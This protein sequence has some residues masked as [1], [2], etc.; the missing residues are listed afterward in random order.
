MGPLLANKGGV[1]DDS[2]PTP[3]EC[4]S[5][6]VVI[7]NYRARRAMVR[8]KPLNKANPPITNRMLAQGRVSPHR[9]QVKASDR[10]LSAALSLSKGSS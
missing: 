1:G 9:H 2:P 5:C 8:P 4:L 3:L 6:T 10:W 7:S